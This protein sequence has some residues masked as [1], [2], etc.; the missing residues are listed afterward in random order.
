ME[1]KLSKRV[2]N[3][4]PSA[5]LAV[6]AKAKAMKAMGIDVVGFGAGEP[7]FDTPENIK[8]AAIRALKQGFTKYCPVGGTDDLKEAI[9][10]KLK[11]DNGLEYKKS[12]ILVSCG[13]K[14]SLYNFAQAFLDEGD[15]VIIPSPYWVSYPE[16]VSLAGGIPVIVKTDERN[17]FKMLPEEFEKAITPRTK[18]VIINSPSNPTG[19]AYTKDE[20]EAIAN[21]ALKKNIFIVSDEIYEKLVYDGFKHVSIASLGR[22]IKDITLVV[23]GVS[24]AYSMTGWRIGYAAGSEMLIKAMTNIQSQSTSNPTSFAMKASVEAL[25]GQQESV[26][27]MVQEFSKRRDYIVKRL[28]SIKGVR[29]FNPLG[30]FYVFPNVSYYYGKTFDGKVIKGSSDFAEYLLEHAKVAVVPGVAFGAD[31]NIRLSYATSMEAIKEGLDR[32]EAALGKLL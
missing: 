26:A 17:G 24:K 3:L 12:E 20:L 11:R 9:I 27:L 15:E 10:E 6:D 23:N 18:A 4:K 32:I 19:S 29:C 7:D 2:A 25:K 1:L 21:I 16:I 5:T 22:E 31:E 14:H 13:A 28:N 8:E 30:A